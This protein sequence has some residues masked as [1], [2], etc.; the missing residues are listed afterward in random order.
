MIEIP[1]FTPLKIEER[2]GG[3]IVT[4]NCSKDSGGGGVQD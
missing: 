4:K 2:K 3:L 1:I